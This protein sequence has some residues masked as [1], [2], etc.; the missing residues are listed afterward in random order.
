MTRR[1]AAWLELVQFQHTVFALPFALAGAVL[2]AASSGG[3]PS[4]REL[5]LAIAAVVA[6]R[7]A[8]MAWNRL[9]DRRFD[10]A[11]PRTAGRA[12]VTGEIAPRAA[13]ALAV[14]GVAA[15]FAAAAALGPVARS[16]AP[17]FAALAFGSSWP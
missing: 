5:A 17:L 3:R 10:A 4:T 15:F 9:V 14:A 16:A 11:N 6:L 12:L 7:T 13:A 1:L 8:A 2:G